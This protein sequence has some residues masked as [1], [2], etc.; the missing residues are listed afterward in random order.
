V[1][2]DAEASFAAPIQRQASRLGTIFREALATGTASPARQHVRERSASTVGWIAALGLVLGLA[3][4]L[5]PSSASAACPNEAFRTGPS[6][7]LPDCRAYELVTPPTLN[8]VPGSQLG[9]DPGNFT[10][11]SVV[12]DGNGYLFTTFAANIPGTESTGTENRYEA[13]RTEA[14]WTSV[15]KSPT[16]AQAVYAK[17]GAY[18]SDYSYAFFRIEF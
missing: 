10:S 16:P 3:V 4:L 11:P 1:R 2:R 13:R 5:A 17:P 6:A 12:A 9:G 14:G 7:Q 18:S 8:G 15:R